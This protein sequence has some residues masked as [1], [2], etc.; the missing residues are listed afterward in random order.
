MMRE[1]V[2]VYVPSDRSPDPSCDIPMGFNSNI[3]KDMYLDLY[4]IKYIM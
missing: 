2:K 3:S 1:Y 4:V